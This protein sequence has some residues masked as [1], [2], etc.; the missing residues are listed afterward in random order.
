MSTHTTQRLVVAA[1]LV[2]LGPDRL[3]VQ[4]R[5]ANAKHG[6]GCLELPGGKVEP[7]EH[8][9]AALARELTEEWGP[10]A[11]LLTL[12]SVAEVLHHVYPRPGPE[13]LLVVYHVDASSWAGMDEARER[14]PGL[15]CALDGASV[16]AF[17]REALPLDEFLAA[18]RGFVA[19]IRAGRVRWPDPPRAARGG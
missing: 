10:H 18:D 12:S 17:D 11:G 2:W 14:W 8:P 16:H 7:G 5:P 19:E 13:V 9:R 1:G 4:R 3:L 15:V 6:A